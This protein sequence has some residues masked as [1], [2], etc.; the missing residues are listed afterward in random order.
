MKRHI[1]SVDELFSLWQ[2]SDRVPFHLSPDGGILLICVQSSRRKNKPSFEQSYTDEG[3]PKTI[4]ESRVL[5]IDTVSGSVIDPLPNECTSWGAQWSPDGMRWVAYA[6]YQ[7]QLGLVVWERTSNTYRLLQPIAIHPFF[8]FEV[9]SWAPDSQSVVVKVTATQEQQSSNVLQSSDSDFVTVFSFVPGEKQEE[10]KEYTTLPG[11]ANGY[12]CNLVRVDVITGVIEPLATNWRVIGWKVAPDGEAVAVL[13]YTE[14]AT[15]LQQFYFDLMILPLDGSPARIVAHH[16]PQSYGICFS[17]S[18][19]S[20]FI[21]YTAQERGAKSQLFVVSTD[22]TTEPRVLNPPGEELDIARE[23]EVPRWSQDGRRIY[24]FSKHGC[25]EFTLDGSHHQLFFGITEY[26]LLAWLQPPMTAILWAPLPD[27]QLVIAQHPHT[28]KMALIQVHVKRKEQTVL[29]ELPKYPVGLPFA[30][31]GTKRDAKV[32][33]MIEGSDYPAEIWQFSID[34]RYFSSLYALNRHIYGLPMGSSRLLEYRTDDG[35]IVHAA[36]LL[37]PDYREGQ[38][39]PVIVEVYG[40]SLQSADIYRFG[41]SQSVL[42]GQLLTSQGYAVLYPDMPLNG[43]DPLKQLS[44]LVL[45]AIQHLVNMGIADPQ[46]VGLLGHSYGGYCTLALLTQTSLFSAAVACAGF[47]DLVSAYVS[48]DE[49]GTDSWL[50][51][52]ESGQGRMGGS[53][54]EKRERYIENSPVFHLDRVQT[55]VLLIGG[56]EDKIASA[57]SEAVFVGLRRLGKPVELRRYNGE[58]HWPGTWSEQSYRDLSQRV[59]AWFDYYLCL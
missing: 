39:V 51:W 54:W 41:V 13:R 8:G 48:M 52:C 49:D 21:A 16:I 25:W 40:G 50:G 17:W 56:S 29:A 19:N 37:P 22:G 10:E 18:P 45:P 35:A 46:R 15:E 28:K 5:L 9:P 36:L 11:W 4:E 58:G 57:Q 38:V 44:R 34:D 12:L 26:T 31:E 2:L 33:L 23:Y 27:Y 55:P 6:Y 30:M 53:L 42:H 14:A 24:C 43:D 32:Y 59:I 20:H 1:F 3:I 47:S 7:G